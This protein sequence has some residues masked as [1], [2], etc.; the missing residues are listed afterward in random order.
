M[1]VAGDSLWSITASALG[2]GAREAE[3]AAAWPALYDANREVI[4]DDPSLIHPGQR[5]ELPSALTGERS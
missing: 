1:V 4:G 2:E 5:L 3:I